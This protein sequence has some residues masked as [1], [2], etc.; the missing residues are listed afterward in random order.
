MFLLWKETLT[1]F[2]FFMFYAWEDWKK[3]SVRIDALLLGAAAGILLSAILQRDGK[4]L[5]TACIP[6]LV[7][8]ALSLCSKGALGIGDGIAALVLGLFLPIGPVMCVLL[9]ALGIAAAVSLFVI[10]KKA[11]GGK[12]SLKRGLPFLSFF[13]PGLLVACL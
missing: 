7:L 1:A 5:L 9:I 13:L 6:G 2:V 8:T 4:E 11:C 12:A 3:R 10:V